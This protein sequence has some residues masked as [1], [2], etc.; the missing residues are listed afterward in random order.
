MMGKNSGTG[1]ALID[2][3]AVDDFVAAEAHKINKFQQHSRTSRN[4]F[5][6][7]HLRSTKFYK[8]Q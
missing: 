1:C 7:N 4:T 2:S 8:S 5:N 3:F 6:I